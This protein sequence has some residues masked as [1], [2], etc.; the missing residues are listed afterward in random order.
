MATSRLQVVVRVPFGI[1]S[2]HRGTDD[3]AAQLGYNLFDDARGILA[4]G[5]RWIARPRLE[6]SA[7]V[8]L[9]ASARPLPWLL[10]ISLFFRPD[11]RSS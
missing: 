5:S 7:R 1:L 6:P 8:E 2:T 3:R 11:W 10:L 4:K 9:G